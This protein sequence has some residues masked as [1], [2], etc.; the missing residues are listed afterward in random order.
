MCKT[1]YFAYYS[2]SDDSDED[3]RIGG[4]YDN[5]SDGDQDYVQ[6]TRDREAENALEDTASSDSDTER[7]ERYIYLD[8]PLIMSNGNL[9]FR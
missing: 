5:D 4:F 2:R 8:L 1:N 7:G 9:I 6:Y 3:S